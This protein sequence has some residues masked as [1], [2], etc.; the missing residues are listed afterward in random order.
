VQN[1]K[2]TYDRTSKLLPEEISLNPTHYQRRLLGKRLPDQQRV[3]NALMDDAIRGKGT[4]PYGSLK[5]CNRIASCCRNSVIT[6]RTDG[7][8]RVV[9]MRCKS[10]LCPICS[11][12]RAA[13][14]FFKTS[15]AIRHM[16]SPRLFTLT[17][18]HRDESLRSQCI[19]LRKCFAELRR[20]KVWKKYVDGGIYCMEITRNVNMK[21]WHPHLHIVADGRYFPHSELKKGWLTVTGDSDIVHMRKINDAKSAATY[22]SKYI[23]KT[24][25]PENIND[26]VLVEWIEEVRGLRFVQSF[27]TL[28]AV[29][30]DTKD[31]TPWTA[32]ETSTVGH[33]ECLAEAAERGDDEAAQLFTYALTT[34]HRRL[35]D[36]GTGEP[37]QPPAGE[38]EI[39]NRLRSWFSNKEKNDRD[40]LARSARAAWNADL[41]NGVIWER[42]DGDDPVVAGR[43][44]K[45]IDPRHRY[46]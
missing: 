29:K 33:I 26:D 30:L 6:E 4:D 31:K 37:S 5:L 34:R 21:Q 36:A 25:N 40:N 42:K 22:L 28:H 39:V 14:V 10:K 2:S 35:R 15:E 19:R 43:D 1:S 13:A 24:L 20:S 16:N 17:L 7:A 8:L 11:K 38:C 41:S 27:G 32:P 12:R 45:T 18:K 23:T 44:G 3:V 46:A 9:E